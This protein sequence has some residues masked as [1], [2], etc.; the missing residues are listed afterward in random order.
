MIILKTRGTHYHCAESI[1]K[2]QERNILVKMC[3][4]I[5]YNMPNVISN[6]YSVSSIFHITEP[7]LIERKKI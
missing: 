1:K 7:A 6:E 3:N 2:D 5:S 4:V